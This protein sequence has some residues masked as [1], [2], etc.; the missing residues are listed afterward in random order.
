M[1]NKKKEIII[2]GLEL[3]VPKEYQPEWFKLGIEPHRINPNVGDNMSKFDNKKGMEPLKEVPEI[4]EAKEM[5]NPLESYWFE[6]EDQPST[7]KKMIDNN[8]TIDVED[9]QKI[10]VSKETFDSI[11]KIRTKLKG[12]PN[13]PNAKVGD[14]IVLYRGKNVFVGDE[15]GVREICESLIM[16]DDNLTDDDLGV[17]YRVSLGKFFK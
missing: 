11:D 7:N 13:K 15:N 10:N 16:K 2:T 1:N 9:I 17:F 6:A 8:E 3:K 5:Q 14:F 12:P 4:K